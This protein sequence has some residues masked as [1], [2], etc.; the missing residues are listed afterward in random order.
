MVMVGDLEKSTFSNIE[1][2]SLEFV[3]YTL[4]PWVTRLEQ[5]FSKSLLRTKERGLYSIR[6]NV[7]RLFD[8]ICK[9]KLLS[10]EM[11]EAT[12]NKAIVKLCDRLGLKDN[13]LSV[14]AKRYAWE[15]TLLN[16]LRCRAREL[17]WSPCD[18]PR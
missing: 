11:I 7:E 8:L 14:L 5:I 1:Q 4:S 9:S 17:M 3:K 16:V 6:F 12:F 2:Q 18:L 10:E 15:D 13:L